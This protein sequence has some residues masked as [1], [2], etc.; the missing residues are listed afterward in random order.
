[1]LD[2]LLIAKTTK[3]GK[4]HCMLLSFHTAMTKVKIFLT[5]ISIQVAL[6]FKVKFY[7]NNF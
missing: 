2:K 6:V 4:Q 7:E 5:R 3:Q 1:M